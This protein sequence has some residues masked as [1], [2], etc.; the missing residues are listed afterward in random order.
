MRPAPGATRRPETE[1]KEV[2]QCAEPF[3]RGDAQAKGRHGARSYD[4]RGCPG[5]TEWHAMD[6]D[7]D[8]P[9]KR[10][11]KDIMWE[12]GGP[13]MYMQNLRE[14]WKLKNDEWKTDAVPEIMDGKNIADFVDP[15]ILEKLE[16]LEKEEE[17]L[18]NAMDDSDEESDL[19]EEDQRLV[20]KIRSKRKVIVARHRR[21]K[22]GNRTVVQRNKRTN[23]E[24]IF[25][26]NLEKKTGTRVAR[27]LSR[28]RK[29]ERSVSRKRDGDSEVNKYVDGTGDKKDDRGRSLSRADHRSKSKTPRDL[30]GM[31]KYEST[32][33]S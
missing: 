25:K 6:T 15:D 24:K 29:R 10:T 9:G 33:S 13:G 21:N 30:S 3:D 7:D 20:E 32:E 19:D 8:A 16:A 12:N 11:Q 17:A 26:D 1:G 4:T 28:G 14:H 23:S 27:N 5:K 31:P 22:G 2:A 18:E